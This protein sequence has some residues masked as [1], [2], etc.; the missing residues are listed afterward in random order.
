M[1]ELRKDRHIVQLRYTLPLRSA[2]YTF[3]PENRK[4]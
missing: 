4:I 3:S 1:I 2:L